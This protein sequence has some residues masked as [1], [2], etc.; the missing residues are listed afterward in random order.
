MAPATPAQNSRH[1]FFHDPAAPSPTTMLPGAGGAVF[2][3]HGR[4]LLV[5]RRDNGRWCLPGGM[6]RIDE[7][8]ADATAR[9]VAEETGL[10]VRVVSLIGVYSDPQHVVAYTNGDVRREFFLLCR[11]QLVGGTLRTDHESLSARFF[12]QEDAVGL[13][14]TVGQRQRIEDA[15]RDA[16]GGVVR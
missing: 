8:V 11:C 3:E 10:Q 1:D 15:F 7:S 5:R 9:E 16:R 13:P 12:A 2:D 4:I 6:I 14:L